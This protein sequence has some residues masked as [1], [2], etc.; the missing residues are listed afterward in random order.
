MNKCQDYNAKSM[1]ISQLKSQIIQLE[2]NDKAYNALLQKYRQ[3][4]NEYQII[5]DAK[6]HLEYELKQKNETT[7]KIL[8]DL[9]CQNMDL[10]NELNE[11]N[12]I[13]QK[14]TADNVNL[15]HNLEDRKKENENFCRTV[16]ENENMINNITQ[17]KIHFENDAMVLNE[18]SKKNEDNIKKLCDQLNSLKL[19]NQNQNDEINSKNIE[20]NDNQKCLN[21]VQC[22][23]ANLNNQINLMNSSLDNIQ[24]Q[25]AL[26]NKTITELTKEI[27]VK[28]EE[29]EKGKG[30]LQNI[31]INFQN[32][33][34]NRIRAENDNMKLEDILK[35]REETLNKLNYLNSSLK[36]DRNKLCEDKNKLM[37]D[38]ERYKSHVII[39]TD[40]TE[41]L[42]DELQKIIDEDT[43]LYNLN[44]AQIQRLQKIIYE[45]KKLLSDEIAAI[46][47]LENYVKCQPDCKIERKDCEIK[48]TYSFQNNY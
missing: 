30:Q 10:T 16:S 29:Y 4:Q 5:N 2:E 27:N 33:H 17:D 8:N 24:C 39:L 48:K 31:K 44:N 23:N 26:A 43:G 42:T 47:A 18:T 28:R 15:F 21:E 6:I 40:Q 34:E 45:N 19:K 12:T 9:K 32:E 38:L 36:C 14:L 46:N 3:L 1:K 22:D 37:N 11:K 35:E 20:I 13:Y 41:K 25:I 7:N